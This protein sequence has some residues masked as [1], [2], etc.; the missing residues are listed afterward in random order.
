[1]SGGEEEVKRTTKHLREDIRSMGWD[2][3]PEPP[4]YEA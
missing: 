1:M 2:L 4:G 3:N